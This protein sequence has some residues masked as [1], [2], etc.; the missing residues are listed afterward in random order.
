[1]RDSPVATKRKDGTDGA[2]RLRLRAGQVP[3]LRSWIGLC[4]EQRVMVILVTEGDPCCQRRHG[5]ECPQVVRRSGT[6]RPLL[7]SCPSRFGCKDSPGVVVLGEIQSLG[8]Y[9]VGLIYIFRSCCFRLVSCTGCYVRIFCVLFK[10]QKKKNMAHS[11][12]NYSKNIYR[13]V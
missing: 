5:P 10:S 11:D 1:M 3:Y 2:R 12:H 8:L 7:S 9:G 13:L 4:E 6:T